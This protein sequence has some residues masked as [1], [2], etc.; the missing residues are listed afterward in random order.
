MVNGKELHL[1]INFKY[2][3]LF[4]LSLCLGTVLAQASD[5]LLRRPGAANSLQLP[6]PLCS[7]DCHRAPPPEGLAVRFGGSGRPPSV[8]PHRYPEH[9]ELFLSGLRL[10]A[11]ET[12]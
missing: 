12:T 4:Q 11:V 6:W 7:K 2:L 1:K 10:A 5:G 8:I 3:T 9:R